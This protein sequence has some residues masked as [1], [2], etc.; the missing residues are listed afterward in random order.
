MEKT[1]AIRKS[2]FVLPAFIIYMLVIVIPS[3]HSLYISFFDWNGVEKMTF[4][5][6]DNYKNLILRDSVF[7]TAI[8][9]N[10]IWTILT[11]IF[12]VGIALLL[13][14][15]LN[16]QFTGRVIYRGIIY[17]PYTLSGI[18]VAIIWIW[19]YH[20]QLGLV[21]GILRSLGLEKITKAWLSDPDFAFYAVYLAGLWQGIGAPVILFLAGLQT[22]PSEVLESALI[23]GAGKVR[24]FLWITIPLLKETFIIVFATQIIGSFKVFDLITAMT[25]GGP[26]Q[27]TQTLATWM[28]EQSFI[29]SNLG[30]GSAIAWILVIVLMIVIIPYV[31][32][33]GRE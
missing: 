23:D 9:N 32:F 28:Y 10:V 22:V 15:I 1:S 7:L 17:F 26:A 29:F 13:A 21:N 31:M 24:T 18:V 5:G 6:L 25:G 19:I 2:L 16:R 27:R 33:M 4:V 8:K 14:T 12:S 20:H 3:F 11:M 30:I